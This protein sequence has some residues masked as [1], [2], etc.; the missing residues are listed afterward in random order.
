[1]KNF[2][3]IILAAGKGTRM[4]SSTPKVLFPLAGKILLSYPVDLLKKLKAKRIVVV[5]GHGSGQVREEFKKDK[6]RFVLQSPQLGTGDA[7]KCAMEELKNQSGDVLILSGDVPLLAAE[8]IKALFKVHEKKPKGKDKKSKNAISFISFITNKPKGY[9]RVVRDS[10]NLVTSIVEERDCLPSERKISEVNGGIYLA[11][12]EFLRSNL[13]K[14]KTSNK[15]GEY[16]LP[17]LIK[18]ARSK[19]Q[20]VSALTVIDESEVMGINNRLELSKAEAAVRERILK[21][22]ML[23][24]VTITAP[25]AT[26]IDYGVKIGKDTVISPNVFLKGQVRIGS[27]VI[28]EEGVKITNSTI[29]SGVIIKSHSVIEDAV[30]G[31]GSEVGPFARI[32]PGTVLSAS[33]RI[34]NFVEVKNSK[35]GKGTKI[36]HLS[37]VGD[38]LIGED[39]N[40]GAGV[41]TCNYDGVNKHRTIIKDNVFIGSDSQLVAPVTIG[42]GAYIG[43]GSTITKDVLS[44]SLALTRAEQKNIKDW[45]K[46]K[47]A[48]KNKSKKNKKKKV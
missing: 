16:Y 33:S 35:V 42:K 37:Y 15:Q 29:G 38:A 27:D 11:D 1:M 4:K 48:K 22:L 25:S 8:T 31:A 28:I 41:I 9:G 45:A 47:K 20:G 10:E 18:I 3:A 24:G 2:T 6:L 32:R 5:T 36:N 21:A 17:D 40:I 7:V 39:V 43:S 30:I 14:L 46:R 19:G 23:G 44:S 26:Y 12:L 34:G 13:A